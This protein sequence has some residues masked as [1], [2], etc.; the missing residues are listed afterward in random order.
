MKR[1]EKMFNN[2][3]TMFS[4]RMFEQAQTL[5]GSGAVSRSVAIA[6]I[7]SRLLSDKST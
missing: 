3:H 7:F 2:E 5:Q 4:H 6:E 1:N